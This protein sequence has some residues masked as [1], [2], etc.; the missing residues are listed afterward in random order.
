[1]ESATNGAERAIAIVGIGAI[2]PDALNPGRFWQNLIDKRYSIIE[3]PAERWCVAD[4]Y[5]P[6]PTAPDKTYSKIGGWVRGFEFDWKKYRIPPRVAAA[7]DP[8]QQWAVTIADQALADY[9]YPLRPLDTERTAVIFGTAMGGE[10]HYLT[11]LRIMFPEYA[12]ALEGIPEFRD[13]SRSVKGNIVEQWHAVIERTTPPITEDTMPGEL[14]N[15]VSGRVANVFS[16]R[17]PNFI[18]DAACASSCAAIQ[19]AAELLEQRQADAVLAGG[20]D[21]NM[22]VSSF[23]K[24][25]KIGALSATGTRPFGDGAD[26]F[27]MGEGSAAF[28]LKRLADA[29]RDGDKIYAVIRGVGGSS[30]GKGKGITA[31]NPVG[32]RLAIQRAW[33]NAGLDPAT[34]TMVEA[35]GTS[36]RVG[37]VVEVESLASM[38]HAAP[39]HGIALGSVKSNFGHLK[40]GAGAA[41]LLKATLALHHR[42]IP[43]TLHAD[44][45]NP[46]IDFDNSPFH[47][48]NDAEEWKTR[49]GAPRRLGVSAY[50]FG[51]ANFHI[52]MEEYRPGANGLGTDK[53]IHAGIKVEQGIKALGGATIETSHPSI[54]NSQPLAPPRGILAIGAN[55]PQELQEKLDAAL[56]RVQSGWTPPR[57]RPDAAAIRA[58]ERLVLDFGN[59]DELQERLL[60]AQKMMGFDNPAAWRSLQPQG[61]FRGSGPKPGKIAFLFPGQGSQ[62]LNMGR[63]LTAQFPIVAETVADGDRVMT[64]ILGKPLSSFIFIQPADPAQLKAAEQQLTETAICQPAMLTIDT[65]IYR[66]LGQFGFK[67]DMVMGHSL[68]EYAALIAAGVMPFDEALEAAAARGHEMSVIEVGDKGWMAAVMG[69]YKVIAETLKQVD[70]YVVAANING[71]SQSVIGGA[72]KAVEQAMARLTQKGLQVQRLPVSHAFHTAI[73]APASAPLRRML[74]RLHIGLPQIPL[75][76]NVNG[77]FYPPDVDAIKG[78]LEKQVASPVQWVKGLE[79]LYAAGART[80]IE[81]GAKKA[82]KGL[83]DDVLGG[84]SDIVSLFTNHPKT[85]EL[86]SLNQA[87]CGLYAAGYGADNNE[88]KEMGQDKQT[89]TNELAQVLMQALQQVAGQPATRAFDRNDTPLGSV[90]ITGTGLGLPGAEKRVMDPDNALRILRGEQFVDLIPERFRKRILNKRVTRV[91]KSEDGSGRFETITSADEV[92]RLAGRPG[93]FDLAAEYGVPDKLIEALDITTQLAMAAGLDALREAGIPLVQTFKRAT[94]GKYLPDRWLLPEAL[95]DE[96]GVIFASAFPGGDRFADEFERYYT[97]QN[98]LSL[99]QMLEDLRNCTSDPQTLSEL[100]RRMGELHAGLEREPYEFDRRFLFRILS[101]GH[102]QFAEYI[103]ARGP[104]TQVNAACAS[105]AQAISMAEDWIRDGRA[106][107]VI[108]IAAD[109]VTGDH[110]MEWVGAGFLATGAAATDDRVEEAAL[111]FDRRRHGTLMGMGACA[112]VL[113]SEDAARERGRRGIVELLSSMMNNSAFHGT[114]LDVNHIAQVMEDLVMSAER[115]FGLNRYA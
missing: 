48:A 89:G 57:A 51:G 10:M 87:L 37:D 112:L 104:N 108:V 27:V 94:T 78:L 32:Q 58:R 18:I 24:F 54:P 62:Y 61:V 92:V 4:Y 42:I 84:K 19:A 95:R 105:T 111:P 3:T 45:P 106:R 22:G 40:A 113:E 28:L 98:R 110:L 75:V 101:M 38:F 81:V 13:L 21:R 83:V 99:L 5:D 29:E 66:L 20:A 12:R 60:K 68:G 55:S 67:P 44:K 109:N 93:P 39:R 103:G 30:D 7:M 23:V 52:V 63:E 76:G 96:T 88:V 31:P 115:R 74:D 90:V 91:V 9:G 1:M 25:C 100:S 71:H 97:W 114:R 47:L 72:S 33:E 56:E 86:P 73:V 49:N 43:P 34:A 35:H 64:P 77:E 82:L 50:G 11:H 15:I 70:G 2:L 65:A 102:S 80:F 26:G 59:R 6:D 36:T 14:A 41:G 53:Q 79:T 17:G 69:P 8:S 107:R 46:N 16:L 85:G